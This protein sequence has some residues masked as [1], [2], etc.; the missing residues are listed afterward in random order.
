MEQGRI[1]VPENAGYW[2]EVAYFQGMEIDNYQKALR[3]LATEIVEFR[4]AISGRHGKEIEKKMEF[5]L[6]KAGEVVV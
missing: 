4:Y 2:A 3:I 5:A 1:E 6:K